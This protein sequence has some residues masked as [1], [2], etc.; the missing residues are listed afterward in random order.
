[1]TNVLNVLPPVYIHPILWFFI[2]VSLFTG[3][4]MELTVIFFIVLVHELGHYSLAHYYKW[5]IRRINLWVFGGVMETDEHATKPL[6]QE[7]L[8]TLAGPLQHVWIYGIL[9]ICSEYSLLPASVITLG[10][11]FNST[12]L[13]FNL[14]PIWP[15]DGG[16]LMLLFFSCLFPYRKA[17]SLMIIC[18]ILFSIV[19]IFL[20]LTYFPFTLS[21]ILLIGFIIWENRL[22]WKQRYYTFIRFLL[23]RHVEKPDMKKVRPIVVNPDMSLM[24][25]FSLFR[26]NSNHLIYVRKS[27]LDQPFLIKEH[28][29]LDI[30][31]KW[32]H[33]KATAGEITGIRE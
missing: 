7:L 22:E 4:F 30:Y 6:K 14:L 27:N 29:C 8:I 15:L 9:F 23:K 13:L 1:M 28:E 3:T 17:H 25:I 10:L 11:Q 33:Y 5:R 20:F 21:A 19:S 31:F 2:L 18:S 16:K 24:R 32:K 26:R 12:I